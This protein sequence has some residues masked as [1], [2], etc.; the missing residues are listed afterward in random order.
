MQGVGYPIGIIVAK[1]HRQAEEAARAV[2]VKY[3][4]LPAI[5]TI[6]QAIEKQ[7][8]WRPP[9]VIQRGEDIDT[10]LAKCDHVVSGEIE[11]GGQDHF[12]LET[13]VS[14]VEP[15]E[16]KEV[17]IHASTQNPSETQSI[18]AEV[19]GIPSNMVVCK[20]KRMGGGFGGKET[21]SIFVSAAAAV[22]A[23]K[24]Q[25]PVRIVLDRD[26]DMLISGGRHPFFG[27]YRVGVTSKGIYQADFN[28]LTAT[29]L[30][31][32]VDTTFSRRE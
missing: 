25:R 22:A 28:T 30:N 11:V 31:P 9:Q 18:V 7:S 14:H 13:Q 6:R 16:N 15:G 19:L 1:T 26:E 32:S 2:Q 20:S 24:L 21:R 10:V 17:V 29:R 23:K 27:K 4:E 8:F 12:Y 3:E 5:I